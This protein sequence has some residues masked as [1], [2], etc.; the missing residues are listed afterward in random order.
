MGNFPEYAGKIGLTFISTLEDWK[1]RPIYTL[2]LVNG[3][4]LLAI[5]AY[6]LE[7]MEILVALSI[8]AHCQMTTKISSGCKK[9]Q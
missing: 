4:G 8:L 2:Q 3:E 6:R 7:S 1:E 9:C 5:S